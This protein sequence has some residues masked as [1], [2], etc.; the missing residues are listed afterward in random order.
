M[1]LP[2]YGERHVITVWGGT[3]EAQSGRSASGKDPRYKPMVKSEGG[4]RESDGVLVPLIPVR[5]A[6]GG[7][8]PD[9]GHVR[10]EGK[11]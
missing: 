2:G 1:G 4:H 10:G 9:F 11:R 8:G 6:P 7:K 5:N 3:G